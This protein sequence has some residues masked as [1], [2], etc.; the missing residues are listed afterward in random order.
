MRL[1]CLLL[2][3]SHGQD[4]GFWQTYLLQKDLIVIPG[5]VFYPD[6]AMENMSEVNAYIVFSS[7]FEYWL[8]ISKVPKRHFLVWQGS[9]S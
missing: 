7:F 8:N 1:W 4:L 2:I 6:L 5:S 9:F 3:F